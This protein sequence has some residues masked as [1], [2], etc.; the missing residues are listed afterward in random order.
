MGRHS[1]VLTP[2]VLPDGGVVFETPQAA[3]VVFQPQPV[4]DPPAPP[5]PPT[6]T[7][8]DDPSA[9]EFFKDVTRI[10]VIDETGRAFVAYYQTHGV[11]F[12]LQDDGRTIKLFAGKRLADSKDWYRQ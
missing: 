7:G 9:G 11:E 12:Q 10:E 4:N 2:E 3:Q 6:T 1:G 5:V 8:G